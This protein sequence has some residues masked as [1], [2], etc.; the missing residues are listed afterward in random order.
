MNIVSW[1]EKKGK[2]VKQKSPKYWVF[3]S[4]RN[5]IRKAILANSSSKP[6]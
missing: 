3:K 5:V 6:I 2:N 4:K 1:G